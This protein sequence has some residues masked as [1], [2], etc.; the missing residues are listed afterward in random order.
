[1]G[2]AALG[3]E[4]P[5]HKLPPHHGLLMTLYQGQLLGCYPQRTGRLLPPRHLGRELITLLAQCEKRLRER[6]K[7]LPN[8]H[9]VL[10]Q[11]LVE[12]YQAW[13][14]QVRANYLTGHYLRIAQSECFV[15]WQL[16]DCMRR[17][18]E[19]QQTPDWKGDILTIAVVLPITPCLRLLDKVSAYHHAPGR[20]ATG[21]W[22][23]V[24]DA[25]VQACLCAGCLVVVVE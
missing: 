19:R 6:I 22:V 13:E 20:N 7:A 16:P 25:H 9:A 10:A 23:Q 24:P 21:H 2:H 17:Q 11:H 15:C 4:L 3:L 8:G 18:L 5:C 14:K 1:M 12:R